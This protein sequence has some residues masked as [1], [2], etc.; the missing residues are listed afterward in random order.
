MNKDVDI[1]TYS[2]CRSAGTGRPADV[3]A[4]MLELADKHVSEACDSNIV[5][6]RLSLGAQRKKLHSNFNVVG[7]LNAAYAK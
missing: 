3:P 2:C 4:P 1:M 5:G 7:T 6:V